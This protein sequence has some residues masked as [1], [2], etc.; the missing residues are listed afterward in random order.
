MSA[1]RRRLLQFLIP[2]TAALS[3]LWLTIERIPPHK[4]DTVPRADIR[5]GTP[6]TIIH[7][8]TVLAPKA[9]RGGVQVV[10]TPIPQNRDALLGGILWSARHGSREAMRYV[11]NALR[12]CR[13]WGVRTDDE[14]KEAEARQQL[15]I[16]Q[17]LYASGL[18]TAQQDES[19]A[20]AGTFS[21]Y[22]KLLDFCEQLNASETA[23][24]AQWLGSAALIGDTDAMRDYIKYA[25]QDARLDAIDTTS[26]EDAERR[27]LVRQYSEYILAS[28]DCW[29]LGALSSSVDDHELA[30]SYQLAVVALAKQDMKNQGGN[31][32]DMAPLDSYLAAQASQFTD[33][34]TQNAQSR[35][36]YLL[37][38]YCGV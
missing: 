33:E 22:D 12:A 21:E 35:A 37:H 6:I 19:L 13:I 28:G 31:P 7:E 5:A 29:S 9:A 16:A 11:G 34:Q 2:S 25:T 26:S 38:N 36:A 18:K 32:A 17:E 15:S 3:F 1:R 20:I 24:W 23:S 14:E 4:G 27:A 30:L 8:T 10:P